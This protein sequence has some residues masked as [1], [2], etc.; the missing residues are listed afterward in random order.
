[1]QPSSLRPMPP[2]RQERRKAERDA[3]KRA[4]AQAGATGAAGAAVAFAKV[5]VN[6]GGDWTT[7]AADS[8]LL[9]RALGAKLVKQRAGEGDREALFSL[10]CRLLIEADGFAGTPLCAAGRSKA[11]VGLAPPTAQCRWRVDAVI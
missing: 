5:N 3:A 1:M 6:P 11:D 7:Q 4:P 9:F 2:S 10:G 8:N